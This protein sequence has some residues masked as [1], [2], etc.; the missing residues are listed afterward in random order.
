MANVGNL[1]IDPG[2]LIEQAGDLYE[3]YGDSVKELYNQVV[4]DDVKQ[5]FWTMIGGI[6]RNL[7][8]KLFG[9]KNS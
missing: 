8:G 7:F 4:T 5:G 9:E 3:K 6:F 2:K 1:K